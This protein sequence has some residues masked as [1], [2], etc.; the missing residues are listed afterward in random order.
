MLAQFA[1]ELVITESQQ[2]CGDPLIEACAC[3][4]RLEEFPLD[5]IQT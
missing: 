3:E 2:F 4:G 5:I 1:A